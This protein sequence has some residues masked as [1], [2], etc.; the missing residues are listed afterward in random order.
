MRATDEVDVDVFRRFSRYF[1][2]SRWRPY[3][4]RWE[5][6]VRL[7]FDAQWLARAEIEVHNGSRAFAR[8]HV[9][10]PRRRPSPEG[11]PG[12][13]RL[14]RALERCGY[15]LRVEPRLP[16]VLFLKRYRP[17][18][19]LLAKVR[20]EVERRL[21]PDEK[22][23][24]AAGAGKGGIAGA[25]LQFR[26]APTW[27]PSSCGW[28]R[29]FR[30]RDGTDVILALFLVQSRSGRLHPEAEVLLH[31]P[32]SADRQRLRKLGSVIRT[33]GYHGQLD[34]ARPAG[35]KPFLFAHYSN[36]R[37]VV[38]DPAAERARLDELADAMRRVP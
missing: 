26:R 17:T 11:E 30:L 35:R 38:A 23:R 12:F 34:T 27:T 36:A 32:R 8:V 3:Y 13:D 22:P 19:P 6:R 24:R 14:R 18:G 4:V 7:R 10:S 21:W 9:S 2:S 5:R 31:P 1:P 28:S 37:P 29:R 25:M 20:R 16:M 33:A 15:E